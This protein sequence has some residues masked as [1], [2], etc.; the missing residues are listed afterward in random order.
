[1]STFTPAAQF[2]S[3]TRSGPSQ[4]LAN[5]LIGFLCP[6]F[7]GGPTGNMDIALARSAAAEM[8]GSF[9]IRN[10]WDLLSAVQVV[11]FAM[12]ALGSIG[13]SMDDGLSPNAVMRCR[14]NAN[15]LQRSSDR[16]RERMEKRQA[17]DDARGE[18]TAPL[19]E[20]ELL[21]T[22]RKVAETQRAAE[23]ARAQLSGAVVGD[24]PASIALREALM[25]DPVCQSLMAEGGATALAEAA[26]GGV[27]PMDQESQVAWATRMATA[28]VELAGKVEDLQLSEQRLHQQRASALNITS[29]RPAAQASADP[30][31]AAP[32]A[33]STPS[34]SNPLPPAWRSAGPA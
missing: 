34:I 24:T 31:A 5:V 27:G 2:T 30:P 16:A 3:P 25:R 14:S 33:W 12:A 1:M 17:Q 6:L 8:V 9:R 22:Y 4:A 29:A 13:L 15:A 21:E 23:A 18:E 11:G 19:N 20:N 26:G 7:L 32:N 10:A 28:A